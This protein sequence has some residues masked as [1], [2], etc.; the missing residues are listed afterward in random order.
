MSNRVSSRLR[1]VG[2]RALLLASC[3]S[4]LLAGCGASSE[5][6]ESV[7]PAQ[8]TSDSV[9]GSPGEWLAELCT[10]QPPGPSS[11]RYDGRT[12]LVDFCRGDG[13]AKIFMTTC[14]SLTAARNTAALS[15]TGCEVVGG[16]GLYGY[17]FT[18]PASQCPLDVLRQSG[19]DNSV[20]G[21]IDPT[22]VP[23]TTLLGDGTA[24]SRPQPS[25]D[26]PRSCGLSEGAGL[27]EALSQLSPGSNT[28]RC[29]A[30]EPTASNFDAC[31]D[32]STILVTIE[33]AT[34]SSPVQ[35][36]MFHRGEYLG[37]GTS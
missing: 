27:T 5:P 7:V 9:S 14:D 32:L 18:S 21:S 24:Q 1:V 37:T 19:F 13:G 10:T 11:E 34:G 30:T 17:Y 15:P 6:A 23:V 29:W 20:V 8:P 35:A 4:V 26:A 28:G 33:G 12:L 3:G 36:L 22:G 16:D 31:R 25:A 2:I